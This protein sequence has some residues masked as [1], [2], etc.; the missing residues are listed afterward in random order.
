MSAVF[1]FP[2]IDAPLDA[3]LLDAAV[4][5]SDPG[6]SPL[7]IG[8][9]VCDALALV[10]RSLTAG[11]TIS[12]MNAVSDACEVDGLSR[13]ALQQILTN[14]VRNA[15]DAMLGQGRVFVTVEPAPDAVRLIVEHDGP[16]VKRAATRLS[17]PVSTTRPPS[18]G[19]GR[20]LYVTYDLAAR[21]GGE[22][23]LE[24]G[25][26]GARFVARF[27]ACGADI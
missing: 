18:N 19:P 1:P 6:A 27:A 2:E 23:R 21:A 10:R 11:V 12:F 13:A 16:G 15:A 20:S 8:P 26:R 3:D 22:V 14:L 5:A 4:E 9:A 7:A 25:R 24:P 17:E